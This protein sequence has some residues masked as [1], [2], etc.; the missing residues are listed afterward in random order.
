MA[1]TCNTLWFVCHSLELSCITYTIRTVCFVLCFALV[2]SADSVQLL[3]C[4][5]DKSSQAGLL[6]Y[7]TTFTTRYVVVHTVRGRV[8]DDTRVHM[9]SFVHPASGSRGQNH[10]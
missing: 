5:L 1:L 3:A 2:S 8:Q 4:L 10:T 6:K 7:T 9:T